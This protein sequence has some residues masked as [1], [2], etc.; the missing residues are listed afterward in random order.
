MNRQ[1]KEDWNGAM[2][3]D[4]G[5]DCYAD[6]KMLYLLDEKQNEMVYISSLESSFW[7]I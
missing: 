5:N 2:C 6:V 7:R 1:C 3:D 4:C